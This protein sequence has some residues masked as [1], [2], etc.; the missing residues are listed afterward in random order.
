VKQISEWEV[1]DITDDRVEELFLPIYGIAKLFAGEDERATIVELARETEAEME[2]RVKLTDEH[3]VIVAICKLVDAGEIDQHGYL[4]TSRI[5]EV[6][7]ADRH[8]GMEMTAREQ[9]GVLDRLGF[10]RRK[11]RYLG[12]EK[13]IVCATVDRWRLKLYCKQYNIPVPDS[14]R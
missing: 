7:N 4:P 1:P 14:F 9:A 6:V 8:E 2:E 3:D 5:L 11:A 12:K 13:P 10:K